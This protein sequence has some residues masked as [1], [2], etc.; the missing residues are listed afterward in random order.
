[1][2]HTGYM[3]FVL[4]AIAT[5]VALGSFYALSLSFLVITIF[6]IRTALEDK[7]LL[8]GLEGYEEYSKKVKYFNLIKNIVS[9]KNNNLRVA[10]NT[11]YYTNYKYIFKLTTN[12]E[13]II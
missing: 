2:R 5:P 6:I 7:T 12:L 3:G 9:L 10:P 8:R 1:M 13:S 11:K 4:M